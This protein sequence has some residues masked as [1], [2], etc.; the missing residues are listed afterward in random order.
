MPPGAAAWYARLG[1]CTAP[2][3]ACLFGTV[4]DCECTGLPPA[5]GSLHDAC[6]LAALA[7]LSSLRLHAV[8]V[9]DTGRIQ[10]AAEAE[11]AG[12]KQQRQQER[13][14]E[15]QQQ[16]RRLDLGCQP[17]SLT[18]GIYRGRLLVDPTA[19]E[20]PLLEALLTATVDQAGAILGKRVRAWVGGWV[21]GLVPL[22]WAP[23]HCLRFKCWHAQNLLA[24]TH[25][26]A[27]P[28]P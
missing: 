1:Q 13:Q 12:Q 21:G 4:S 23:L 19:E 8:T 18:C 10:R 26:S 6:L 27:L 3:F 24:P 2:C 16:L 14:Q 7:A 22:H 28:P 11:A 25:C 17:V 9:D 20:E 15:G 5:D